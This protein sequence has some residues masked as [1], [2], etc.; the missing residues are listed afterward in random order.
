MIPQTENPFN[1][2]REKRQAFIILVIVVV[3]IGIMFLII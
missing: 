1:D 2:A 3:F